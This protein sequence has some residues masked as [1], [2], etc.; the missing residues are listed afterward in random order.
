MNHYPWIGLLGLCLLGGCAALL[1]GAVALG[2]VLV[3]AAVASGTCIRRNAVRTKR[4]RPVITYL[5]QP[6]PHEP[7]IRLR[8]CQFVSVPWPHTLQVLLPE[9]TRLEVVE[10]PERVR[11]MAV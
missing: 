3:A 8:R 11:A 4:T 2:L 6:M 1:T 10:A 9:G 7:L 5:P